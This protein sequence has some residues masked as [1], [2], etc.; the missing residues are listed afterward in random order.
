M[1]FRM[2]NR[3]AKRE[4]RITFFCKLNKKDQGFSHNYI[5]SNNKNI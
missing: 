5:Y 4:K 1:N 2:K 3:L